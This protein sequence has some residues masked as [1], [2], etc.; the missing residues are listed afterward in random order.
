MNAH[1]SSSVG[2]VMGSAAVRTRVQACLSESRLSVH[3]QLL[4]W[5]LAFRPGQTH[6]GGA[7]GWTI[8][9]GSVRGGQ[10]PSDQGVL[11]FDIT[12]F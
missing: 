8:P 5:T 4:A 3:I 11:S 2:A 7:A 6:G 10:R 12:T 9:W 1:P